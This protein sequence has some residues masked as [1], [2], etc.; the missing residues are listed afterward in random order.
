MT[1]VCLRGMCRVCVCMG[2]CGVI[3]VLLLDV[4][5]VCVACVGVGEV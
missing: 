3:V 5:Y 4:V 1:R 2:V